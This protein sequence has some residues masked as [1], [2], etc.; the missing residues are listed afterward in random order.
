MALDLLGWD[1]GPA[2]AVGF[3][4]RTVS[5]ALVGVTGAMVEASVGAVADAGGIGQPARLD[6]GQGIPVHGILMTTRKN[7]STASRIHWKMRW[8][9]S[10]KRPTG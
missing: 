5:L 1:P 8:Q 9:C 6:G 2:G 4:I 10:E 7:L 3:A